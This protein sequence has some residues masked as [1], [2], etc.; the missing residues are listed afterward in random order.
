MK[1]FLGLLCVLLVAQACSTGGPAGPP[2]ATTLKGCTEVTDPDGPVVCVDD[3]VHPPTVS[4]F[5]KEL[6]VR[7]M[8]SNGGHAYVTWKTMYGADLALK[9]DPDTKTGRKC[10]KWQWKKTC[11]NDTCGIKVNPAAARGQCSYNLWVNGEKVD[12]VI[13]VDEYPLVPPA[14]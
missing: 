4:P 10:Y 7:S 6:H 13:I 3:S 11:E 5:G 12:P 2:A 1:K 9:I 14:K 8:S